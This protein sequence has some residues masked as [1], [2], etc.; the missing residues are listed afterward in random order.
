MVIT[1]TLGETK[2]AFTE[3]HRRWKEEPDRFQ[4]EMEAL[5]E[6]SES[7]ADGCAVYFASLLDYI[8]T[9]EDA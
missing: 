7:Y 8:R 2:E 1:A 3:W 4:S 6:E 9:K 5:A